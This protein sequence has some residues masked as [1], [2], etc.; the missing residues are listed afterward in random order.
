MCGI[1][2]MVRCTTD[3]TTTATMRATRAFLAL[4]IY[5]EERGK[6]S[7]GFAML[8]AN[9]AQRKATAP[10]KED[11]ESP[12]CAIDG[13]YIVK[14]VKPFGE[15]P[16]GAY[17][18]PLNMATVVIGHTRAAS[19]GAADA[20]VNASPCVAGPL[21]GTHNGDV[22]VA[23]IPNSKELD[24]IAFGGTDTERLYLA[25][26]KARADRRE[27]TRVMKAIEG[28]ASLAFVDRT[29]PDRLYL[30]RTA[31]SPLCYTYD[32]DGN[33]YYAS[34][35]DWFRRIANPQAGIGIEFG[36]IVLVP[37]G[38]LLTVNTLTGD[39]EDVRR[40][41][42]TCR[43]RDV[44][45]INPIVYKGFTREDKEV[46]KQLLRHKVVSMPL[47]KWPV[48]TYA[49]K[50]ETA[51]EKEPKA[52]EVP[53][54]F[55]EKWQDSLRGIAKTGSNAVKS[56][57]A[58]AKAAVTEQTKNVE[59]Q[60]EA[61]VDEAKAS[62]TVKA[63]EPDLYAEE[64]T[65]EILGD[66]LMGDPDEFE[67]PAGVDMDEIENLCWARGGDFDH[68]SYEA[69]LD[70][71]PDKVQGLVEQLRNDV[72]T[73]QRTLAV[74]SGSQGLGTVPSVDVVSEKKGKVLP[75]F[76]P[77]AAVPCSDPDCEGYAREEV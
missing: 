16:L 68:L 24:T 11:A 45:I 64:V 65:Y 43:E 5:S 26:A 1:F 53:P 25:I 47:S 41:T 31:L 36:E 40:F 48:L 60:A 69:I 50:I 23:S 19:Q 2:G 77:N 7:A 52:A 13:A 66:T 14:D 75:H 74:L 49:P 6:D 72:A 56:A 39:V 28:R 55:E 4:G 38:H 21:I 62:I 54:V 17:L 59:A 20:R 15:L 30:A 33:F 58:N 10:V 46:D 44:T 67:L 3:H 37:E 8:M 57:V 63:D 12:F 34:N 22:A 73:Y 51:E 29:R 35:P 70:A 32:T 61:A 9:A 18:V 42:P 76:H 27:M 71:E